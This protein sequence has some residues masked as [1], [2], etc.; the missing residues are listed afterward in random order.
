MSAA[1]ARAQ[2]RPTSTGRKSGQNTY[3]SVIE[4]YEN[5]EII[6]KGS[7]GSIRKVARKSDGKL[8][9]RKELC[10]DRMTDRD[11]KQIVA[12]VNILK[13]LN[14]KNIVKYEERFADADA[15]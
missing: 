8:F 3:A 14:H 9:A 2:P 7:F 15:K 13:A 5:V 4:G 11:R 10:Y 1:A 12:E 6:G